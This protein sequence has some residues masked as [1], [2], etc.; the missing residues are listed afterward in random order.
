MLLVLWIISVGVFAL[1]FAA[2]GSPEKALT[3]GR[4]VSEETLQALRDR[5]R[6]DDPLPVQY[7]DW[8]AGVVRLDFGVSYRTNESV[9]GVIV[10]R[11]AITL[12]LAALA[13]LI[14]LAIALP[15]AFLAAVRR[16]TT[17]D[18][19]ISAGS[20]LAVAVPPFALGV[21]MLYIFAIELGWFPVFG[22]GSGFADR[23]WHL[24]LPA[25]TLSVSVFALVLKITRAALSSA[26]E[27]EYVTFARARGVPRRTVLVSYALRNCVGPVC[28]A[29]GL[30]F[31]SLL[32]ATVIV[33]EIF[34]LPGAGTLLVDA[35]RA[36]DV[37]VLQG[38]SLAIAALILLVNLLTD[39]LQAALDPRVDISRSMA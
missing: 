14:A 19:T 1:T 2:P 23:I 26:L 12:E 7:L 38:I 34:A 4:P 3:A 39:L 32:A 27:E 36:Q 33:E 25:L 21:L 16:R 6:L 13:F 10:E 28:T 11:A 35:A 9:G 37:P 8:L 18:R 20:A 17:V 24:L 29:A 22:A 31:G 5:Y 15:L 30:T